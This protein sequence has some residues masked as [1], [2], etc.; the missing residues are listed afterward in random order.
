MSVVKVTLTHSASAKVVPEKRYGL[1][2][3]IDSIKANVYSHFGTPA[4]HCRLELYDERDV[5][6]ERAMSDEKL[7]GYYQCKDFYRIHVVDLQ[8]AITLDNYDDVTN[9][10]KYEMTEGDWLRRPDNVRHYKER[11]LAQQRAQMVA[12]GIDPPPMLDDDSFQEEAAKI[13]IGDRCKCSPGDRLGEVVYVGRIQ[14]LKPGYYVGVQ[15]D[16]PVGKS[17]GSVKGIRIF[18]CAPLYGGI[19]RPNQVEV[20]DFP[21]ADIFAELQEED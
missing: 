6:V 16:E 8:P 21:V 3:S 19:L 14:A 17:D 13:K 9:V 5:L 2:Q 18:E 10:E 7:L 20:G 15:F 11:M 4:E 1:A 12:D